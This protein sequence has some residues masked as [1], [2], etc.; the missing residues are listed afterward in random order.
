MARLL[1]R[2]CAKW[3]SGL[4]RGQGAPRET[5]PARMGLDALMGNLVCHAIAPVRPVA[6]PRQLTVR[7]AG[8]ALSCSQMVLVHVW[9][10]GLA[11]ARMFV[12]PSATQD[13]RFV[14]KPTPVSS[15]GLTTSLIFPWKHVV[16]AKARY[17]I[18]TGL[19]LAVR[20]HRTAQ[21]R[22]ALAIAMN[23]LTESAVFT[24]R[25]TVRPAQRE[26]VMSASLGI[27]LR[28]EPPRASRSV[29]QGSLR[30]PMALTVTVKMPRSGNSRLL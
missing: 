1:T 23:G 20:Q 8:V 2:I 7:H 18:R 4:N 16:V 25:S 17:Q 27:C 26:N 11:L 3:T 13:A 19:S 24:V 6:V 15:E 12:D 21:H 22:N 29:L 10:T 28:L 14:R 5:H 30:T 9:R